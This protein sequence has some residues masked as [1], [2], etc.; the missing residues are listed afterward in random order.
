MSTADY[1]KELK[2]ILPTAV[3]TVCK[4]GKNM[5]WEFKIRPSLSEKE[6]EAV[7]PKMKKIFGK[8]LKEMYTEETGSH[9]YVY[10]S[11]K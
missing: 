4:E 8:T 1:K 7:F 11:L 3:I 6:H 5:K 2:K 10:Q 9:F